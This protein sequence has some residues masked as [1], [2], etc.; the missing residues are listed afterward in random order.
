[1]HRTV[2]V[3]GAA[4]VTAGLALGACAATGSTHLRASAAPSARQQASARPAAPP[5]RPAA[6]SGWPTVAVPR[7][8]V[9]K[10]LVIV[11]ENHS[12]AQMKASMPY[13][14][15]LARRFSYASDWTA[16]THPSLP[17]YLAMQ[18]GSTFGV[19]DDAAP[20]AH[21]LTPPSVFASVLAAGR[22]ARSYQEAM[23]SACLLSPSGRYAVKHNPWA[24]F[25]AERAACHTNDLPAGTVTAGR[26]HGD[27]GT[28]RLPDVG[29]L[30]PDLCHDAHDCPLATADAWLRGWLPQV[31]AGP[32]WRAGRLAVVVTADEDDQSSGNRV[33]TVVLHPALD[34]THRIVTAPLNSY[35]LTRLQTSVAH[36]QCVRAGCTAPDMAKAFRLPV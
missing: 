4:A 31:L 32:D 13:L 18:A 6:P 12:L 3:R 28:G 11:E 7:T 30:I 27:I 9:T 34:G 15:S 24:Y 26:L 10:V 14:Y 36:A 33:L 22:T 2:F 29:L 20:A 25:P 17:N 16:Q 35:S 21:P 1:M 5:A 23:P 19:L 8:K